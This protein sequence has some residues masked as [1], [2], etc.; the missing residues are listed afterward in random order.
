[1]G[2]DAFMMLRYPFESEAAK[3]LNIDIFET[4]Y[5]AACEA[6]CELAASQGPYES[7]A[8]SPASKGQLQRLKLSNDG[9]VP[10][11]NRWHQPLNAWGVL[12][13]GRPY[14]HAGE[15]TFRRGRGVC[16]ANVLSA[17]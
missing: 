17:A 14:L 15:C 13:L 3:K 6:S 12:G 9:E 10:G 7:F 1:M 11:G 2:A 16:R 4:I 5:F 8:G